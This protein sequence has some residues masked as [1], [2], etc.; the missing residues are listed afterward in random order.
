M[1]AIQPTEKRSRGRPQVRSDDDTRHLIVVAAAQEFQANGYA[2]TNIGAVAARAGISTKTLYRLVPTKADLFAHVIR[3]RIAHLMA[4]VDQDA[5]AGQ[6]V[7]GG[8]ERILFAIGSLTLSP[9]VIAISRLV[10]GECERFPEIAKTFYLSA[11]VPINTIVETWLR[12]QVDQG[13][14]HLDDVHIASSTL[15]GMMMEPQRTAM[16]RQS[17]APDAAEIAQR[18]RFAARVF[19]DGCRADSMTR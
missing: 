1:V 18:A 19:I 11:A 17:E 12:H 3:D 15:R 5:D 14:L 6:D 10:I 9:E 13:R 8:L 4:A 2:G 16:L 7:A